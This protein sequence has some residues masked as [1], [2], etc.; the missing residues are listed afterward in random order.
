[1]DW[2]CISLMAN[3]VDNVLMCLLITLV[4]SLEKVYSYILPII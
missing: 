3:D 4:S 1:M 2:I